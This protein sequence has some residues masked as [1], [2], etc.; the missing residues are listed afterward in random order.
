M[1][2]LVNYSY[3][4][5]LSQPLTRC[6]VI[7]SAQ[8]PYF[9]E[10][11]KSII[12]FNTPDSLGEGTHTIDVTV[13]WADSANPYYIDYFLV[14]PLPGASESGIETTR[15][16]PSSTAT[17]VHT[18]IAHSIPVGPIVGGVVGGVAGIAILLVVAYYFLIR[19]PRGGQAYYF[20]K[21]GAADVLAEEGLYRFLSLSCEKC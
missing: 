6:R 4:T 3:G 16:A 12:Y 14:T 1:V 21:P 13:T 10:D 18:V 20:E 9:D 7:G 2:L 15:A 17:V 11:E 5:L 19:R 8:K